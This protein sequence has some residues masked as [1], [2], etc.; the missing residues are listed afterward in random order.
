LVGVSTSTGGSAPVTGDGIV[1]RRRELD[2]LRTWLGLALEGD[3]RLVLC[4]GEPGIG[5]T[6]LAQ[7]LAGYALAAGREVVWGHCVETSGAPAFWPWR[8][9]L[10]AAGADPDE[11][12]AHDAEVPQDR[13]RVFD[14]VAR[15]VYGA[16]DKGGLVLVL[17]DVHWA[18]EPSLLVLRHLADQIVGA[19]LLVF[20]TVRDATAAGA[21]HRV[22]PD[23]LRSPGVARLDLRGFSVTEVGE[24]LS[25]LAPAQPAPDP[26]SVHDVTGGNPLF[27]REVARAVADGTWRTDRPPRT[28]L[29]VVGARLDRVSAACRR[30]V[31]A[32][33]VVGRDFPV[34]IVA[35]AID[36]PVVG[37]LPLVDEA[38]AHGLLEPL[39]DTGEHRFVHALTRDA[40]EASLATADRTALHRAVAL[41]METHFAANLSEHVADI[42]RHWAELAPYGEAATAR[43]WVIKAADE[44]VR[45]LAYEEGARL[46][47]AAL[48]LGPTAVPDVERCQVLIALG[49]AAYLA[50]DL[51]GCAD[52][53]SEAAE[54]ARAAQR[55]DLVAEAALVLEA[56]PDPA[57]NAVAGQLCEE[58][59]AGLGGTGNEAL[60]ARLLAQLS[61]LAFY[62]GDQDRVESLSA[63]ALEL[64][65]RSGD[66]QALVDALHARK[67]A[68]P[69]PFG[70]AERVLLAAEMLTLARRTNSARTAMWGELWRIDTLVEAGELALAAEALAALRVAVEQV[71]GPVSGWHLDRVTAFVAQARGRY[72]D[73]ASSA[74]RGFERMLSV[75]PRPAR[76]AYQAL[77]CALA[78]HVGVTDE[79]AQLLKQPL[80]PLPRF[81]TMGPLL[82][83]SVLLAAGLSDEAAAAYDMAGPVEA[84]SPPPFLVLPCHVVG[85]IAA[86][87]LG[88]SHDLAVLLERL[89][90]LRGEH[91]VLE[92]VWYAGP[93]DLTLGRGASALGRLDPAVDHL[94][95]AA[96]QAHRAGAAGF[97]AEAR[98]HLALA[99][100][101]RAGPGDRDRA[102]AAARDADRLA[103]AL[104]MAAYLDR[105]AALVA[106]LGG[107]GGHSP[108]SRREAEVAQLVA[109][110]LTNRQI[111]ERLVISERTAENHVQH[112]LTKLGFTRRSQIAGWVVRSGK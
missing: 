48:A 35:A 24:Q 98:Y 13:F 108:L 71:G 18:D 112:V 17:D 61:H 49:R 97:V 27:V 94:V 88:R 32:A 42:A 25:R 73:A 106:H 95:A 55:P 11:V 60:R 7:E 90:P 76:G 14:E 41:A 47:R 102:E 65:R 105:T 44:A 103:R 36:E 29:D 77:L 67:E 82:R 31:Q 38:I 8:Q 15:T 2:A 30:F 37:C 110:G 22:L 19:R 40:V 16:A 107:P 75:E 81:R 45:R 33:A 59:L 28:V 93:V 56:A 6:R 1:G 72:A 46:Y 12:L 34:G 92:G 66:D 63:G 9:V 69:G 54:A 5:K 62:D 109:E 99:L 86:A 43:K 83:S 10:K 85:S 79:L 91:A 23:L 74:R 80:D 52:A 21:L 96:E 100:L 20:A 104:G 4:V 64:A 87:G 39:G 53:A 101:A 51:S 68:C 26:R 57:I 89:E 70:G 58:A 111:A 50:G 84:W 78:W 3:G